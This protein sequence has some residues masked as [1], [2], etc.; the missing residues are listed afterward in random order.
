MNASILHAM[1]RSDKGAGTL[2][3]SV[4]LQW[5]VEHNRLSLPEARQTLAD[6]QHIQQISTK[7]Q[8]VDLG[9]SL[10]QLQL[11]SLQLQLVNSASPPKFGQPLNTHYNW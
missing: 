10:S 1:L 5:L 7:G 9:S 6:L 8:Q 4:A 3:A 2:S 11:S